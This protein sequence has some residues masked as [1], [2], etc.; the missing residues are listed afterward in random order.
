MKTIFPLSVLALAIAALPIAAQTA[1][2]AA[3]SAAKKT[4]TSTPAAASCGFSDRIRRA[5]PASQPMAMTTSAW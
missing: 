2:P 5:V 1:N 4:A 3:S